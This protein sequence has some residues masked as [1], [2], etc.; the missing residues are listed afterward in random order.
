MIPELLLAAAASIFGVGQNAEQDD[1]GEVPIEDDVAI[2]TIN[3]YQ[4]GDSWAGSSGSFNFGHA[5]L[6]VENI[7]TSALLLGHRYLYYGDAITVGT[8]SIL[9]TGY[10]S[11]LYYGYERTNASGNWKYTPCRRLS[12]VITESEF[13]A[14]S[15]Q[16]L[17]S[18]NNAWGPFNT[19]TNFAIRLWNLVIP[20]YS[21]TLTETN[22]PNNLYNELGGK[23]G[24]LSTSYLPWNINIG[25]V[26]SSYNVFVPLNIS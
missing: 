18:S 20:T 15:A 14:L 11:G 8:W 3:A 25:Y 2:L 24:Y 10:E 1:R 21:L 4:G 23:A 16:L 19:C 26:S 22:L 17:L 12:T 7:T 9:A 6:T 13:S 5:F